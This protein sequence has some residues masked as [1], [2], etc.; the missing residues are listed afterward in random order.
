MT[1]LSLAILQADRIV[2]LAD[3]EKDGLINYVE[4]LSRIG[5]PVAALQIEE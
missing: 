5:Q 3:R 2:A 4:F 1:P